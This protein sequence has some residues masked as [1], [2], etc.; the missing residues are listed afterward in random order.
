ML[1]PYDYLLVMISKYT[2]IEDQEKT[3]LMMYTEIEVVPHLRLVHV[4]D[5]VGRPWKSDPA[6]EEYC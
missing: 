4:Y 5:P 1:R 2:I 3:M 6:H